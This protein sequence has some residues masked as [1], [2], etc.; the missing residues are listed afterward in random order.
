MEFNNY[1]D[2][3]KTLTSL[4][5]MLDTGH[6][7]VLVMAPEKTQEQ[8]KPSMYTIHY[9]LSCAIYFESSFFLINNTI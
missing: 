9:L 1:I 3:G 5:F 7:F 6:G 4:T 8:R 2:F